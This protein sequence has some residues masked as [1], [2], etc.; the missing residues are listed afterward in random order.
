MSTFSNE[1]MSYV[2][3]YNDCLGDYEVDDTLERRFS[4]PVN[5]KKMKRFNKFND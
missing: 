4:K 5:K 2:N 3:S 1:L